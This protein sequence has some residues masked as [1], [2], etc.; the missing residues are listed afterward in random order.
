MNK[1][2]MIALFFGF[3]M[4]YSCNNSSD[5]SKITTDVV[6]NPISANGEVNPE[7]LPVMTFEQESYDFGN[8]TQGEKVAHT[9]F[10]TNTGKSNLIITS[11]QGSCGCTVPEYPKKPI[12]PGEKASIEVVFD[13]EGK[14]GKQ[15]K[16]VTILANTQPATSVIAI[17]GTIVVP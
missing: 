8:I 6:N 3:S 11:A 17:T 12:A 9:Y 4:A 14:S 1:K 5:E 10:F 7:E 2:L 15:H 13:S 16:T